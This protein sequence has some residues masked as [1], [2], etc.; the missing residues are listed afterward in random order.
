MAEITRK[1][2]ESNL[3]DKLEGDFG[4]GVWVFVWMKLKSWKS[5]THIWSKQNEMGMEREEEKRNPPSLRY[6][7]RME[8]IPASCS[9]YENGFKREKGRKE[10]KPIRGKGKRTRKRR[11]QSMKGREKWRW[12]Q[13]T[14]REK[15]QISEAK[16]DLKSESEPIKIQRK[17]GEMGEIVS[18]RCWELRLKKKEAVKRG[19]REKEGPTLA[20]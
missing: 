2:M 18:F 17:M 20:G 8:S 1:W 15:E 13:E 4:L 3:R 11:Y 10:R 12:G 14:V 7:L 16:W 5:K 19:K 6:R 9:T